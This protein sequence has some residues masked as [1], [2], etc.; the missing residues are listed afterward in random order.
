VRNDHALTLAVLT[1]PADAEETL[2]ITHLSASLAVW[3]SI[4]SFSFLRPAA[5]AVSA[6][7]HSRDLNPGLKSRGSLFEFDLHIVAEIGTALGAPGTGFGCPAK[8]IVENVSEHI[9]ETAE[10]P[11]SLTP[12]T[13]EIMHSHGKPELIVVRAFLGIRKHLVGLTDLLKL[14]FR[15][16]VLGIFIRMIFQSHAPIGLLDLSV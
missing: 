9:S 3:A 15:F 10:V 7:F 1:G 13:A 2:L 16:L 8:K 5:P 4:R 12:K 11:E 6:D 14:L